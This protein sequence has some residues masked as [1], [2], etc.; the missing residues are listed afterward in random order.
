[1]R[2]YHT[3]TFCAFM[4]CVIIGCSGQPDTVS[5][6]EANTVANKSTNTDKNTSTSTLAKSESTPANVPADQKPALSDPLIGNVKETMNAGGYSYM[7]MSTGAGD[8]WTAARQF[9]VAVGDKVELAGL[10]SMGNFKSKTLGRVFED[11]QF[12]G[13]ATVL[14]GDA[15]GQPF[16]SEDQAQGLPPGH[17]QTNQPQ[18]LPAG[19]PPLGNEAD[20]GVKP[21]VASVQKVEPIANGVTVADLFTKRNELKDKVVTFRGRVVKASRGILGVNWMHIQDGTGEKGTN[22]I[23]VTSKADFAAVGSVVKVTGTLELD[24][25]FGSGYSYEVIVQNATITISKTSD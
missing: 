10:V 6:V 7:L 12:V 4:L 23:T 9:P 2:F 14:G 19:H 16:T 5:R 8:V 21:S 20:G 24:K 11:I 18:G 22:D 1:M 17:P 3:T 25:D 15:T 13:R